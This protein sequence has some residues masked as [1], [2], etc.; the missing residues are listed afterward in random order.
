MAMVLPSICLGIRVFGNIDL[1]GG[2]WIQGCVHFVSAGSSISTSN[3]SIIPRTTVKLSMNP[4]TATRNILFVVALYSVRNTVFSRLCAAPL[5]IPEAGAIVEKDLRT[6]GESSLST[7]KAC[8][9]EEASRSVGSGKSIILQCNC[10]P[11]CF[12]K[13]DVYLHRAW[14]FRINLRS[15][16]PCRYITS[17]TTDDV[18]DKL[19]IDCGLH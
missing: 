16:P 19:R 12:Q 11:V 5:C 4:L 10:K 8:N 9:A 18:C 7:R 6:N 3:S 17:R 14:E 1:S 13:T 15:H 2:L